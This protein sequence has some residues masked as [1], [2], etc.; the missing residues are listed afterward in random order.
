MYSKSLA[1]STPVRNRLFPS[2][3]NRG[4][5]WQVPYVLTKA[6]RGEFK[7]DVEEQTDS[8]VKKQKKKQSQFLLQPITT[9]NKT[10]G[11][12]TNAYSSKIHANSVV[13]ANL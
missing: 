4:T 11:M 5:S 7:V 3:R 2:S 10:F 6:S 12:I 9:T 1:P 8:K 13:L